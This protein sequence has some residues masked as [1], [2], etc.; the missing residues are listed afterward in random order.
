VPLAPDD[1]GHLAAAMAHEVR[2]P[3][4]TLALH[5]DILEN[6]AKRGDVPQKKLLTS[7]EVMGREIERISQLLDE[8]LDEV[9]PPELP[10]AEV[11]LGPLI[12]RAA[13]AVA[14]ELGRGRMTLALSPTLPRVR[15]EETSLARAVSSLLRHA[16]KSAPSGQKVAIT[17]QGAAQVSVAYGGPALSPEDLTR[18]F[19]IGGPAGDASLAAAKQV[20]R[21]HGGSIGVTSDDG[22]GTTVSFSLPAV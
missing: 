9:G 14:Q 19:K 5:A 6:L 17:A 12:R 13:E 18:F 16:V 4:N 1:L 15:A 20:I 3:L 7:L 8:Y 10:F 22:A 11:E 21:S 2:N